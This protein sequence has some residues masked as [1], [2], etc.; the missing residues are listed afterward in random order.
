MK[1]GFTLVELL[2]VIAIIAVLV[3][4]LLPAVNAAR[5]ASRKAT[6]TNNQKQL[7]LAV[8]NFHDIHNRYPA[9]YKDPMYNTRSNLDIGGGWMPLILPFIEQPAVFDEIITWSQ[10]VTASTTTTVSDFGKVNLSNL[11]C[12]SDGNQKFWEE[13][14]PTFTSYKG[15]SADLAAIREKRLRRSWLTTAAPGGAGGRRQSHSI[16]NVTDGLSNTVMLSEGLINDGS[17]AP[18]NDYRVR[19]AEGQSGWYARIPQ[20][21]MKLVVTGSRKFVNSTQ[22]TFRDTRENIGRAAWGD[23]VHN[24]RFYTLMP[25]NSPNCMATQ[26]W[27]YE[28]ISASSNHHG[29]V[30]VTFLDGHTRFI[31][32]NINTEN[33]DR[34]VTRQ[35][36]LD[37]EPPPQ[38][39]DDKGSFSYGVWSSLGSINGGETV[40]V[41]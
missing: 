28:W 2:V 22:A 31:S 33:L 34:G 18:A 23:Y 27:E 39:Y 8:H 10:K 35:D 38:P 1:K 19:I 14:R 21:C 16:S 41:L 37:H 24:S 36:W 11:F 15:S 26:A 12:P 40:N 30:V 6:C 25:P 4:L 17:D 5:E 7:A 29:G 13:G 9:T 3:G 32:D 20:D